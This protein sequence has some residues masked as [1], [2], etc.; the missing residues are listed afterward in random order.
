MSKA[1][2]RNAV[3]NFENQRNLIKFYISFKGSLISSF[4][5]FSHGPKQFASFQN[6]IKNSFGAFEI[7]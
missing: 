1:M 5:L 7:S 4:I 2:S 6:L 3:A